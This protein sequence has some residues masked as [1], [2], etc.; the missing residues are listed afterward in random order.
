MAEPAPPPPEI[1]LP[2]GAEI[3]DLLRLV[4]GKRAVFAGRWQGRDAIFRLAEPTTA[5]SQAREWEEARRIWP[6]MQGARFRVAEPL[7]FLPDLRLMVMERAPGTPLLSHLWSIAP[8]ERSAALAP[9]AQWLR[10]YTEV[11]EGWQTA[12]PEGWRARAARSAE[13]QAFADLREIETDILAALDALL[14]AMAGTEWRVAICHGDFHPNNLLRDGARLTGIDTG[15]S[16]R[17]P[18]CKDIAR[19][20]MHL[21]RRGMIPSGQMWCGV[22]AA[23]AAQFSEVFALTE[24]E[25]RGVLPFFL[26]IE[27]LLRV[28]T[29]ALKP[30]RVRQAAMVYRALGDDLARL[31][32]P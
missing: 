4:P 10:H 11:S 30:R 27:A 22:D 8:A 7:A 24:A 23:L 3:T 28:E 9:A 32:R 14:P 20:L 17:M 29:R 15:G 31:A 13:T 19:F 16:A 21:A 12:A 2:D 6:Y 1:D 26:G 5:E 25:R 18:V